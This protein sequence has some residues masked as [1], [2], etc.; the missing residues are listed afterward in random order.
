MDFMF[1]YSYIK[2]GERSKATQ[3][4]TGEK[5]LALLRVCKLAPLDPAGHCEFGWRWM[6]F[7]MNMYVA[8]FSTFKL[9]LSNAIQ[10]MYNLRIRFPH[11][12]Q[13]PTLLCSTCG[14]RTSGCGPTDIRVYVNYWTTLCT[15]LL[16]CEF[17]WCLLFHDLAYAYRSSQWARA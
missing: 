3:L 6:Y 13:T 5:M 15:L 11:K 8:W 17:A 1:G 14:Y 10:L 12:V 9:R 2:L 7:C 4:S 16:T